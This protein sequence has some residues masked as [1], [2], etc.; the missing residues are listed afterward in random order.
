MLLHGDYAIE[1]INDKLEIELTKD[2]EVM[3]EFEG[4]ESVVLAVSHLSRG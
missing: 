4:H 1:H 3:V 2:R